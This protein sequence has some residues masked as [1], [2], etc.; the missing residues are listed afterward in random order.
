MTN[1]NRREA[2]KTVIGTAAVTLAEGLLSTK[3][4]ASQS[5][6]SNVTRATFFPADFKTLQQQTS[7]AKINFVVGGK[8]PRAV[9]PTWLSPNSHHV[10]KDCTSSCRE[11]QGSDARLARI[12]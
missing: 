7:G 9:A 12:W 1:V 11:V 8:G 2:V 5:P 4:H 6:A 3:T 10:A